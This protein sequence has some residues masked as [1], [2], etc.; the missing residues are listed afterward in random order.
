ML[1]EGAEGGGILE[2][3]ALSR[4]GHHSLIDLFR[5]IKTP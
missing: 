5:I 3:K 2:G 4:T 1:G